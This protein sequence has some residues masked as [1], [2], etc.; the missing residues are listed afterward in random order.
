MWLGSP[1]S[2]GTTSAGSRDPTRARRD[3]RPRPTVPW[4]SARTGQRPS[5]QALGDGQV[6]VA[7]A[8]ADPGERAAVA[9][10]R[11]GVGDVPR[12][13]GVVAQAGVGPGLTELAPRPGEVVDGMSV[14]GDARTPR[15]RVAAEGPGR[16][17][18]CSTCRRRRQR[19]QADAWRLPRGRSTR[20]SCSTSSAN[21]A[22]PAVERP[23]GQGRRRRRRPC[24]R[25]PG[26]GR[27]DLTCRGVGR[28]PDRRRPSVAVLPEP[29]VKVV[30]RLE[31][32]GLVPED[33]RLGAGR[34]ADQAHQAGAGQGPAADDCG[35]KP[36]DPHPVTRRGGVNRVQAP[37]R[38]VAP[39]AGPGVCW[40]VLCHVP[41]VLSGGQ[42]QAR[43][44]LRV[45]G[46]RDIP[47]SS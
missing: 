32:G 6:V 15:C 31:N 24:C 34:C 28:R 13:A 41:V 7:V 38:R 40:T 30:P 5:T 2:F 47:V 35:G 4:S 19:R 43:T 39:E 33:D 8:G 3:I 26:A 45:E 29:S 12:E 17:R 27:G 21:S 46:C 23:M 11:I 25:R 9:A 36:G 42:A 10:E 1:P 18:C 37:G 14:G 20:R 44:C 16:P 22:N